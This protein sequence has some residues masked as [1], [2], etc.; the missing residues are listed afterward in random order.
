ME[1]K[2][3]VLV[4]KFTLSADRAF[5][6]RSLSVRKVFRVWLPRHE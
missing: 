2:V 5:A 1:K 6:K 4:A 3:S